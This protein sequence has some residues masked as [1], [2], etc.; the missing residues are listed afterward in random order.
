MQQVQI[1]PVHEP[2][3]VNPEDSFSYYCNSCKGYSRNFYNSAVRT[4]YRRC[5]DCHQRTMKAR[6]SQQTKIDKLVK[7][8]KYNFKYQRRPDVAKA[9]TADHVRSILKNHVIEFEDQL[10]LVKTISPNYD[11]VGNTWRFTVV[12]KSGSLIPDRRGD[13]KRKYINKNR[14]P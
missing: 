6:K 9:V 14:I 3:F 2:L 10:D 5:R 11:P 1:T 12:F 4:E 13:H 7:K 8:L